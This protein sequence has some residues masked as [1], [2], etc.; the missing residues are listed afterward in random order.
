MGLWEDREKAGRSF[1][2]RFGNLVH[3]GLESGICLRG[4]S[5]LEAYIES[6]DAKGGL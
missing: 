1:G 4:Q 6:S 2:V 5:K 3:K